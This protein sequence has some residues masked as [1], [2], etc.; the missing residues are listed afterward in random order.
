[1]MMKEKLMN[2]LAIE[3]S[4]KLCSVSIKKDNKIFSI[5]TDDIKTHSVNLFEIIKKILNKTKLIINDINC[6]LVSNGPGSYTGLRI[7]VATALGLAK[8]NNIKIYYIDTLYALSCSV[9]SNFDFIISIIDAKVNRVYFAIF[10]K[11]LKRIGNDLIVDVDFMISLTNK[12][13][14]NK[15]RFV[16]V[17]NA[18]MA[19]R[20]KLKYLQINYRL[21]D[22]IK[23]ISRADFLIKAYEKNSINELSQKLNINYMQV[24]QAERNL[25]EKLNDKKSR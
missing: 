4:N 18:V 19:Y 10:D 11:D 15:F 25:Q 21:L 5:E 2:I 20:D 3:T 1:M 22:D 24:S 17:G 23:N 13:F 7:G 6:I 12:Y 8:C 9:E 14:K 16:L